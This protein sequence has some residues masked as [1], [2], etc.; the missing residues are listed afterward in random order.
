[1]AGMFH[2]PCQR[3]SRC[4]WCAAR[5]P[6]CDGNGVIDAIQDTT[7]LV[8][9]LAARGYARGREVVYRETAGGRHDEETW[10]KELP[11]FLRWAWPDR[12]G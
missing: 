9:E 5:C 1:M 7:E 11:G 12:G 6:V 3:A 4:Q 8:D 2:K 10:A